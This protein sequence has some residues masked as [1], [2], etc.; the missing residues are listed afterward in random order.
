MT[1]DDIKNWL[2]DHW[3]TAT[4]GAIGEC[5][6]G[7]FLHDN[8]IQ[9]GICIESI[10]SDFRG[11]EYRSRESPDNLAGDWYNLIVIGET[12]DEVETQI[13]G[14]T[15]VAR[16]VSMATNTLYQNLYVDITNIQWDKSRDDRAH[17][18][19]LRRGEFRACMVKRTTITF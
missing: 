16:N 2:I 17:K 3:V 5:D 6:Y 9:Y 19:N 7:D 14:I 13:N 15:A 4:Y 18:S 11:Y 1:G 8:Q 12:K 10:T